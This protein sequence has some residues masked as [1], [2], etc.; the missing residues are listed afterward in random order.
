MLVISG[1]RESGTA[2]YPKHSFKYNESMRSKLKPLNF[3]VPGWQTGDRG[4]W[5]EVENDGIREY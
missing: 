1:M 2:K 3:N 5:L 4:D